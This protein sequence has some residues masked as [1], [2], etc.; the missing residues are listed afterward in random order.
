MSYLTRF[1]QNVT[2]DTNNTSSAAINAGAFFIGLP[3]S[4][5]G[6][7]AIQVN[8][9][10]DKNCTIFV[11]QSQG[12]T[13]GPGTVSTSGTTIT[14]S[15]QTKFLRDFAVGD[16]III[17]GESATRYIATIVTDQS[18][19][20]TATM[21][22]VSN[23]AYTY[24][25][26]DTTDSF[27]YNPLT[28]T[29]F[30]ITVQ[31]INAYERIR[32]KNISAATTTQLRLTTVLCPIVEVVP[33][34]LDSEQNFKISIQ[35]IED[36]NTG[37]HVWQGDFHDLRANPIVRLVGTT[38][39]GTTKDTNFW[40]ETGTAGTGTVSQATAGQIVLNTGASAGTAQY[41]TI[42]NARWIPGLENTFRAVLKVGDTGTSGNT[43]N[44]GAF[45]ANNGFF[46]QLTGTTFNI[47]SR[48]ATSDTAV[49]QASWNKNTVFTLDTNFH[50]YEIRMTY[51]AVHFY[52]DGDL[53]HT[54]TPTTALFSQTLNLPVTLFNT[55]G[56]NVTM[57]VGTA[58]ISRTGPLDSETQFKFINSATTTVCKYGSGRLKRVIINNPSAGAAT[59]TIDDATSATTPNIAILTVPAAGGGTSQISQPYYV[60]FECPFNT[61]LTVVTTTT[62]PVT[63][64]YE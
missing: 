4:T 9:K 41:T 7:A 58:F 43:R 1:S 59:I 61:G 29:G 33:R 46:F 28:T 21:T 62:A 40:S 31:A 53:K 38:F 35:D 11:D 49:A 48:S 14:G 44:W 8:L 34:A 19:T 10:S 52:I 15:A 27:N 37:T 20:T 57:T 63:V 6:V 3:T 18:M 60:D 64:I 30:G 25:P 13:A 39:T 5:L 47:V 36:F 22:G 51:R 55:A 24:Y 54:L 16:Q 32:V 12:A 56:N 45:D 50:I 17:V 42:R 23:A 26:W 2:T